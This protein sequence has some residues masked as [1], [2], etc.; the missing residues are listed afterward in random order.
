MKYDKTEGSIR[1]LFMIESY[2]INQLTMYQEKY[3]GNIEGYI[4]G[5]WTNEDERLEYDSLLVFRN[6][7]PESEL[8][9]KWLST[10]NHDTEF[11]GLLF[12]HYKRSELPREIEITLLVDI[13]R[14]KVGHSYAGVGLE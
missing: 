1:E 2:G 9:D 5:H 8:N 12:S 7:I 11:I 3:Q 10:I 14:R 6:Y 4:V 13:E